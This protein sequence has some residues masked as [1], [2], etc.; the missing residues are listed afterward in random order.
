MCLYT[1]G[2]G[3]GGKRRRW[4]PWKSVDMGA[5]DTNIGPVQIGASARLGTFIYT[6][7]LL[8]FSI[9]SL[10]KL[11]P[12]RQ[13]RFS[14]NATTAVLGPKPPRNNGSR[15]TGAILYGLGFFSLSPSEALSCLCSSGRGTVWLIQKLFV[16]SRVFI[17]DYFP[18]VLN[19]REGKS[20][21]REASI[22]FLVWVAGNHGGRKGF[23]FNWTDEIRKGRPGWA[24]F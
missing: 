24:F 16:G 17:C 15:E 22:W 10:D 9:L 23:R 6:T 14:T 18:Y 21:E 13:L 4:L 20:R 19:E 8:Y 1:S 5:R 3:N 12:T 2:S 7:K 11:S